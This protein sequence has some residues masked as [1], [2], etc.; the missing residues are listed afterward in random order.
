[1]KHTFIPKDAVIQ[2]EADARMYIPQLANMNINYIPCLLLFD[3]IDNLETDV[4][5]CWKGTLEDKTE[6]FIFAFEDDKY[7]MGEFDNYEIINLSQESTFIIGDRIFTLKHSYRGYELMEL[8][9]VYSERQVRSIAHVL[10][11]ET[12]LIW[13][14]CLGYYKQ[15]PLCYVWRGQT[16]DHEETFIIP[17]FGCD[18]DKVEFFIEELKVINN[19]RTIITDNGIF[20]VGSSDKEGKILKK[21]CSAIKSL[22]S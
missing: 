21:I 10:D 17:I 13:D 4:A 12:D 14:I 20:E 15:K 9:Y 8:S 2:N 11:I 6:I 3:N 1:M 18:A 5:F 7:L 16:I 19:E 22:P